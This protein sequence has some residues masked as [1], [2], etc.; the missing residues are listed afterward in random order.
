MRASARRYALPAAVLVGAGLW[1]P[2]ALGLRAGGAAEEEQAAAV[3]A[4]TYD[5]L[6]FNGNPQHSGNNTAETAL[7]PSN[8]ASLQFL[9]Q[10]TL[11]SIADGAPVYLASV[12]TPGVVRDL[13]FVT[14]TAGHIVALDAVTG[15]QVWSKQYGPGNCKINNGSNACYTTSSP[16]IDPNRLY[17]YSYGLDGY[18][19]KYQVGDGIEVTTGGWPELVT[20]K[21]FNEKG[22]SALSFATSADGTTYL[23]MLSGGYPG[24]GGDYQGH[25][26]AINLANGTQK[27]FNSLCSSHTV[28]FVQAP[29]TPDCNQVQSAL[30]A[31]AGAVY[32]DVT[33]RVYLATGNGL[34]NGNAGGLSWGD[35]VLA[36]KPDGTG[37]AG[38]PLDAYTPTNFQALQNA[39]A[40]L[41]SSAPAIL[42]AP[43]FPGRLAMQAGKDAVLRLINLANLSG[44]GGPG[45]I[46]GELQLLAVPQGGGVLTAPAVWVNPGHGTTWVFVAN[47]SGI[48]GLRLIFPSGVP[49]LEKR[50][51]S[52]S[53][54]TSPLVANN[55]LYYAASNVI[56][57][58][59]P[60][61]GAPLWSDTAKVGGIH[62]QSPVVVNATLYITDQA[63]HLTAYSLPPG[64]AS[65]TPTVTAAP[66]TSTPTRTPT[67]TAT[68][69]HPPT[70]TPTLTPRHPAPVNVPRS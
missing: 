31:R 51:Q 54:G 19:H 3:Q 35:S 11:P 46:G 55:V 44:Q 18:V 27:V 61:T 70:A 13:L 60:L 8:V 37:S 38:K 4:S 6:Q 15:A 65:P 64:S 63:A 24:D 32:D 20:L 67:N 43:A 41:G 10:A 25:L 28:H 66:P 1:L 14:T 59:E 34:Y 52:A 2:A 58:L 42:P 17:V 21:G 26:T 29:G 9:F 68:P 5:W 48:S 30:W 12:S 49:T 56:R 7:G 40:D 33:D 57:A 53:G 62:W 36:V 69:R 47:Q 50:W 39:D 22:G 16:A 45:F 23:Y